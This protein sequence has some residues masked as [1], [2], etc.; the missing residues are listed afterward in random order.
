MTVLVRMANGCVYYRY[1]LL[2]G[3]V[4]DWPGDH[5]QLIEQCELALPYCFPFL[6]TLE[7]RLPWRSLI[8]LCAERAFR[9]WP[10]AVRPQSVGRDIEQLLAIRSEVRRAI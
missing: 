8:Y 7:V 3:R 4:G 2:S 1:A 5:R 10:T 6:A 9:L